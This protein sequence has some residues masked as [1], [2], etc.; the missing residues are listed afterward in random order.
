MTA[1]YNIDDDDDDDDD[2]YNYKTHKWSR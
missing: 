2:D 1:V